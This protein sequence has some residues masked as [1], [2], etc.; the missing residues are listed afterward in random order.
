[1]KKIGVRI[2]VL[3]LSF[4]MIISGNALAEIRPGSFTISPMGGGYVFDDDR[5]L[6]DLGKTFKLGLGY[7]FTQNIGTELSASYI[8]TDANSV[9]DKDIY[10]VQ[11]C[12]DLLYHIMPDNELVPYIALGVSGIIFNNDEVEID[13]SVQAN[14]GLGFKLAV[15]ENVALRADGRYYRALEEDYDEFALTAGLEF[16]I[17]GKKKDSD[18]DGVPDDKDQCPNTL[19]GVKVDK[20]GCPTDSD[21][22]GVT[23]D[24]DRCPDTIEGVRVDEFGC[25]I[26]TD[27]YE[28]MQKTVGVV[29]ALEQSDKQQVVEKR[30]EMISVTLH[31]DFNKTK[32]KSVYYNRLESIAALMRE[33]PQITAV[34]EG[35]TDSVGSEKYNL[36]LSQKRAE[37]VKQY[38]V[39]QFGIDPGRI[40][41]KAMGE[42]S[43]AASNKTEE[44][45]KENRRAIT[46][47]IMQ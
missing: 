12:L 34:I 5:A 44:G 23:D 1:M 3:I 36:G 7:N 15:S 8:H 9:G 31:F 30:P 27:P 28:V 39:E 41:T 6:L 40:Y 19:R 26:K 18:N 42:S 14:A 32:V 29:Q 25:Q 17:G 43:P 33:Y 13:D 16:Q 21:N 10:A 46:I 38:I 2:S 4:I 47:T 11:P 37:S 20:F 45:R 35:H 24:K 22:D